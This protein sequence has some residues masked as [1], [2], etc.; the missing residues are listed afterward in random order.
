MQLTRSYLDNVPAALR[1]R[2]HFLEVRNAAA[3]LAAV[4]PSALAD[5]ND[6]LD[7][8]HLH[9]GH[10][11]NPGGSKSAVAREIDEAFRRR[12]WLETHL[13]LNVDGRL[14]MQPWH[15]DPKVR[16]RMH[17]TEEVVHFE[18]QTHK[19]DN[20]KQR[21]AIEVEW[22]AKDG[23]LDRDLS[24]F[25]ALYDAGVIDAAV[26]VTRHHASTNYAANYLAHHLDAVNHNGKGAEVERFNTTTTTNIERLQWR[27][28]RGDA[29]GCP[30]LAIGISAQ[31][32][33]P[34]RIWSPQPGQPDVVQPTIPRQDPAAEQLLESRAAAELPAEDDVLY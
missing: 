12:R 30:V 8:F 32:Y 22:N 18:G 9:A 7:G 19:V 29:A 11:L 25:R 33:T 26:I 21:V 15:A 27:L 24:A 10:L 1:A 17:A 14:T 16:S 31:T 4:A 20:F 5:L 34:G 2:Y 28:A 3:I 6:V 23:N 13:Q